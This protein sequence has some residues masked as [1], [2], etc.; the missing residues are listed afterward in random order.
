M[1]I[2]VGSLLPIF[3]RIVFLAALSNTPLN[4]RKKLILYFCC[5]VFVTRVKQEPDVI[6]CG[7]GLVLFRQSDKICSVSSH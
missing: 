3:S 7:R 6:V 2:C 1:W 4:K 5:F